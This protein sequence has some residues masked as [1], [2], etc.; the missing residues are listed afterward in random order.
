M[1]F[2]QKIFVFIAIVHWGLAPATMAQTVSSPPAAPTAAAVADDPAGIV[3]TL[4][5]MI[6]G[7]EGDPI[8]LD[9]DA[10]RAIDTL[11]FQTRTIWTEG[12]VTF[13]GTRLARLLAH[14]GVSSGTVTLTAVNNYE[15]SFPV[16]DALSDDAM[17]AFEMNG[18]LMR[19]RDKGPLWLVYPYDENEKYQSELYYSRSIW[20]LSKISIAE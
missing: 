2:P 12:P 5:G 13:T 7:H 11:S 8:S 6:P 14:L 4:S 10:L 9:L 15:V 3:L 1:S 16:A 19:L 18:N 20:Q 17:I